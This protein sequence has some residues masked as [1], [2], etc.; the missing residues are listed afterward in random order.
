MSDLHLGYRSRGLD[1]AR[2]FARALDDLDRNVRSIDYA[3]TLGDITHDGD[4]GSLSRYLELRDRSTITDWFE[5]AG[6]HEHHRGGIAHYQELV[7]SSAPY[8]HIDGNMVWLFV[9]DDNKHCSGIVSEHSREWLHERLARHRDKV[10]ILCTHQPP[11]DTVRRSDE[12]YFSLHPHG[13]VT[14]I[15]ERY[16]IALHVCGHEHHRPYGRGC[17]SEGGETPVINVAS[18]NHAYET[19]DSGSMILEI[20][21]GGKE[22][23]ARRRNHDRHRYRQR[24]EVR[25]PLRT[26][27]SLTSRTRWQSARRSVLSSRIASRIIRPERLD[28]RP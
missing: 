1:G 27:V 25:I 18:I 26:R 22:I 14:E 9:S 17:I 6:N 4:R 28:P 2:W 11:P 21:D 5:L 8:L 24:F 10:I 20:E 23:I 3:L 19:G 16:P 13:A 7:G 15:L 12:H